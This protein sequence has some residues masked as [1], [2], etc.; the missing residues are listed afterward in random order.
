FNQDCIP[1]SI[2][3]G[4]TSSARSYLA[5]PFPAIRQRAAIQTLFVNEN[6]PVHR[7]RTTGKRLT[8][9]HAVP[10]PQRS[11]IERLAALQCHLL[12]GRLL[13]P[14]P[15]RVEGAGRALGAV[16]G[17]VQDQMN[18]VDE[19]GAKKAAVRGAAALDQ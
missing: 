7:C 16:D 14:L 18:F 19:A 3:S 5:S 13:R 17:G 10:Q 8:V 4:S 9:L 15:G 1:G 11:A 2:L 6:E 12:K